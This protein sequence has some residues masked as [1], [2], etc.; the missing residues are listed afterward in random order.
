M[1]LNL[2]CVSLSWAVTHAGKCYAPVWDIGNCHH[3]C[4]N[5]E[6]QGQTVQKLIESGCLCWCCGGW[7]YEKEPLNRFHMQAKKKRQEL[8]VFCISQPKTTRT[9]VNIDDGIQNMFLSFLFLFFIKSTKIKKY[10]FYFIKILI[11]NIEINVQYAGLRRL[12]WKCYKL[13]ITSY[14]N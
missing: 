5:R 13:Q 9:F 11:K 1:D 4:S 2:C 14:S 6:R 7:V 3:I 12:L 8:H 10:F